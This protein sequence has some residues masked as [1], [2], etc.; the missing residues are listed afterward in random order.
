MINQKN[1]LPIFEIVIDDLQL[2]IKPIKFAIK[3]EGDTL[4]S[5]S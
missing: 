3:N 2:F 4:N 5:N 1:I